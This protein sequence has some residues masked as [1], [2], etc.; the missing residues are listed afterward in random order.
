MSVTTK[1]TAS[2]GFYG[3]V[4]Y[5][6]SAANHLY[7]GAANSS[8]KYDYR[9]RVTFPALASAADLGGSRVVITRIELHIRRNDGGPTV[10]TAGC[11]GSGAWDAACAAQVSAAIPAET[12]WYALD[13]TAMAD[14]V[15]EYSGSWYMHF[16]GGS[17]RLRCDG[18][19]RDYVPYL[20]VTWEY[21][22]N[23]ISSDADEAELGK[24]VTFF[25][26]PEADGETHTLAYALG[27]ASGVIAEG[28]G[29]SIGW[30][31][32][33]E[34][35]AEIT[36][37][38]TASV[39]IRMT[40]YAN[41][42][43]QRTELFYQ[44]VRVPGDIL[45]R[46]DG[47]NAALGGGLEGC[48][49]T[50][51]STLTLAPVIDL[52]GAMGA[53]L[54]E[55]RAEITGGQQIVWTGLSEP[56]PGILAGAAATSGVLTK[57]GAV[58][59]ELFVTDSRGRTVSAF[60]E[61]TACA[62][63]PP[64]IGSFIV[65]RCAPVYDENEEISGWQA[66]DMG[67]WVWVTLKASCSEVA[68]EGTAL[69]S[70]RWEIAGRCGVKTCAAAGTEN[71]DRDRTVFPAPVD[72]GEQ[73]LYV[74]TVT[75]AVGSSVSREYSVLPG[76][77]GLSLAPDR[78]GVGVGMAA[79]GRRIDP[80]FEVDAKYQ[81]HFYGGAF[82]ADGYRMDR[83]AK[84]EPLTIAHAQYASYGPGFEPTVSRVGPVVFLDGY[85]TNLADFAAEFD[86]T[87]AVLPDWARPAQRVSVLQQGSGLALWWM[88]A[89]PDGTLRVHRYRSGAGYAAAKAGCQFP[90]T[91]S[92]LAGDA[93]VVPAALVLVHDGA[94][95]LIVRQNEDGAFDM[96]ADGAGL[97]VIS[98]YGGASVSHDGAGN[99]ILE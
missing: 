82:G 73:W 92:W 16:T 51:R 64:V 42:A 78:W 38:E 20:L 34:L 18:T 54:T 33:R 27:S 48:G 97:A 95:G 43:V 44:T 40:A 1:L 91:A 93:F 22:A 2:N 84:S 25:V 39:Q 79:A 63:A 56:E 57:P 37:G 62:Y 45:P 89:Y 23:T 86:H 76:H 69:N 96:T 28:A 60:E 31:P 7:I 72:E 75:D 70:L 35:A 94:G 14:A 67:G 49:L 53:T 98:N 32:P 52:T 50:G 99:L 5:S 6:N 11:S 29:D 68:P 87:L 15:A 90:L 81:S 17:P 74:L 24:T 61:F 66:D 83:V 80:K 19:D 36:S 65:E 26:R 47:L 13:V 59:A 46:I 71:L 10:V 58:R 3:Y 12:G 85:A 77:A 9:S 8:T 21:A 30:T 4:N 41:G 55:V 88:I